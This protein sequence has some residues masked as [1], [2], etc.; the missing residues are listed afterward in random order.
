MSRTSREGLDFRMVTEL[1]EEP[2][3]GDKILILRAGTVATLRKVVL[4][5]F[6]GVLAKYLHAFMVAKYSK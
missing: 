1:A 3:A 4:V 5:W 6:T 2:S